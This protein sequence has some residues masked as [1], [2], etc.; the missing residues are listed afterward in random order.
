[1]ST[2]RGD[3]SDVGASSPEQV[4]EG[5]IVRV[6]LPLPAKPGHV[7][8]YLL[9]G[10]DGWTLV[11]TGLG[12][13]ELPELP[14]RPDR[15]FITHFHPDHV[16]GAERAA[17]ETGAPVLQGRLDYEQCERVWGS[18]DWPQ[19][20]AAWFARHGVPAEVNEELLAN[21][22][23]YASFVRFHWNPH[24]VEPG[25]LVDGWEVLAAPG[26]AD[27]HLCL[28]RDGILIAGDHLL[29]R[30]TPAVGLYPESRPDPLGDYLDS[31]RRTVALAP[32]IAYP[33]HGDP[34][35]DPAGRAA[36]LIE[37]HRRRLEQTAASLDGR[38]RSGFE[39][40]C[41]LFGAD[42]SPTQRRFAVAEALS[43]LERLVAEGAVARAGDDMNMLYTAA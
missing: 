40:S 29:G 12:L 11:D 1:V 27:G 7:H 31:L 5:G 15:I 41:D 3:R 32:R 23:V 8:S 18:D 19:R 14:V 13:G 35:L 33:G 2:T 25:E 20:L 39:V 37:H 22:H 6:T 21:G 24:P 42:L 34:V 43:H 17:A 30:I 16:G 9:P 38:A 10:S 28:H 4:L 36:A 26:H